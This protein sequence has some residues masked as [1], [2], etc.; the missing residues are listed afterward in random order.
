MPSTRLLG[1]YRR[2]RS[3]QA[4]I[5]LTGEIDL[6]SAHML[7]ESLEQCL[8]DGIRTIDVDLTAVTFCDYR[9]LSAFLT[10]S[11]HTAMLGGSLRLRSPSPMLARFLACTGA[12]CLLLA[13]PDDL[14]ASRLSPPPSTRYTG[15]QQLVSVMSV[16]SGGGR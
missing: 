3:N 1:I 8:R 6:D 11:Q 4:S 15:V 13:L 10:A 14:V 9:G 12:D 7:S 16:V 5:T 2:D